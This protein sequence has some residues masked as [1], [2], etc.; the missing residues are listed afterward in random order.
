MTVFWGIVLFVVTSLLE[1]R[2]NWRFYAGPRIHASGLLVFSLALSLLGGDLKLCGVSG[3][4]KSTRNPEILIQECPWR[5]GQRIGTHEAAEA[6]GAE[7]VEAGFAV[8]FFA[9][10]LRKHQGIWR[11]CSRGGGRGRTARRRT[12]SC[13][14]W[15]RWGG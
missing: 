12:G 13:W 7:V 9:S 2:L 14:V 3:R 15:C 4:S 1:R 8:V 10:E 5:I 6:G 11:R